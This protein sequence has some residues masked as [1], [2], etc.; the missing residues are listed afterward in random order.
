MNPPKSV[1]SG[2]CSDKNGCN[3]G[4]TRWD[5]GR[6]WWWIFIRVCMFICVFYFVPRIA[7]LRKTCIVQCRSSRS[8]ELCAS[9]WILPV[10]AHGVSYSW[11]GAR[12]TMKT[13]GNYRNGEDKLVTYRHC[14]E[15]ETSELRM[16]DNK[17]VYLSSLVPQ[18][19]VSYNAMKPYSLRFYFAVHRRL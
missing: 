18:L 5:V 4:V 7:H 13:M 2:C 16:T 11:M 3:E 8:S 9:S 6:S 10:C 14:M 12:Y 19:P 1:T 17:E 15:P